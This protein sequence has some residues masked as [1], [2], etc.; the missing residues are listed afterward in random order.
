LVDVVGAAVTGRIEEGELLDVRRDV[1]AKLLTLCCEPCLQ[2]PAL[3]VDPYGRRSQLLMK[4]RPAVRPAHVHRFGSDQVAGRGQPVDLARS[5]GAHPS[6][7]GHQRE[8][9]DSVLSADPRIETEGLMHIA[10]I[11]RL[12]PRRRRK[13]GWE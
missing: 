12:G 4:D 10:G 7:R 1:G 9:G 6:R 5:D 8:P 2:E 3:A 11:V 13:S